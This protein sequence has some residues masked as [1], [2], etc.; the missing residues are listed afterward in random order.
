M[1]GD[2]HTDYE[3]SDR[4]SDDSIGWQTRSG[5]AITVL[6]AAAMFY[7]LLFGA[8]IVLGLI[9][10]IIETGFRLTAPMDLMVE[11]TGAVM[12]IA[13]GALVALGGV[14]RLDDIGRS[15]VWLVPGAI[16]W[17]VFVISETDL[18]P[19]PDGVVSA[20]ILTVAVTVLALCLIPGKKKTE[21]PV[22]EETLEAGT[23][24]LVGD[25]L[26]RID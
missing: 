26:T 5:F 16:A 4:P 20:S 25:K 23:Y 1:S 12:G 24:L 14:S 21:E 8:A 7:V 11:I 6:L 13:A 9:A 10:A 18:F 22:A 3:Y 19:A 17:L 2:S 15:L